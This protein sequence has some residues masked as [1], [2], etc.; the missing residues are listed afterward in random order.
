M[1]L[2]K[3]STKKWI[4]PPQ[5]KNKKD[6]LFDYMNSLNFK[7]IISL[8]IYVNWLK[9]FFFIMSYFYYNSV[10]KF[11]IYVK[12]IQNKI[13]IFTIIDKQVFILE[14]EFKNPFYCR[15]EQAIFKQHIFIALNLL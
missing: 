13:H 2:L 7:L 12:T 3:L 5:T 10:T 8:M 14:I 11:N 9:L 1:I 15:K 6:L 4:W